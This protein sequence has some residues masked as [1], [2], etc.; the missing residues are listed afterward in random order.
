[1]RASR[2]AV[3]RET[4]KRTFRAK[5]AKRL[6]APAGQ[7]AAAAGAELEEELDEDELDEEEFD[8]ELELSD[9]PEDEDELDDE[10]ESLE[11]PLAPEPERLSLR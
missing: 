7:E 11:L 10:L 9:D 4:V 1:M 2:R 3:S 5:L 6:A 8:D